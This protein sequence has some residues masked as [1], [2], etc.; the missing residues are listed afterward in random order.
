MAETSY[1]ETEILLA[2]LN[3]DRTRAVDLTLELLPGE[4]K[5]FYEAAGLLRELLDTGDTCTGCGRWFDEFEG[6]DSDSHMMDND[7]HWWH[8]AC[9]EGQQ[10]TINGAMDEVARVM[11]W[12]PGFKGSASVVTD[13]EPGS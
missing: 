13:K 5:A 11:G 9:L 2:L 3:G 4:R 8:K 6:E 7:G 12:P 1:T 10:A